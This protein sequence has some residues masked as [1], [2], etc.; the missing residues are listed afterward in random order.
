MKEEKGDF[1]VAT[2]HSTYSVLK[3]EKVFKEAGFEKVRLIPVPSQISSDC[4]VTVRF[5]MADME[6]AFELLDQLKGDLEGIF[7]RAGD[8][9][10]TVFETGG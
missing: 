4:G 3:A 2:F 1:A 6:R 9:W 7:H 5:L 10:E 8:Q